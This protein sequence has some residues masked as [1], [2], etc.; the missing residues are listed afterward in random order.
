MADRVG[1][2]L[3]NYRLL[4]LLG[5]GGFAEVYLGEHVFLETQAAIKVLRTQ[6]EGEDIEQFRKEART[7]AHLIHPHIVRVLEFG[8]DGMMPFL[9]MDYA[10]HGSLRQ[11]HPKGSQLPLPLVVSYVKQIAPALH[12]AHQQ[13]LIHRDIKP[14]NMLLTGSNEV[15]LTDFGIATVA[16][17]QSSLKTEA[18]SGTPYY[19]APEQIAGKALPASDQYSLGIVVYEWLTGTQP[20]TGDIVQLIYQHINNTPPP[21][22]EKLPAIAPDVEQV[23]LQTLAKDPHQRFASVVAFATALEEA[24]QTAA[25]VIPAIEAAPAQKAEP[26]PN[27]PPVILRHATQIGVAAQADALFV[28]PRHNTPPALEIPAIERVT[29]P[30]PEFPPTQLVTPESPLQRATA[31]ASAARPAARINLVPVGFGALALTLL[32]F[33]ALNAEL[34]PPFPIFGDLILLFAICGLVQIVT[35]VH[36]LLAKKTFV[37]TALCSYGAFWLAF[38]IPFFLLPDD[39]IRFYFFR[40][41]AYLLLSWTILTGLFILASL[42]ENK[43]L[44]AFSTLLFLSFL[45][46]M[47]GEINYR[48]PLT[49]LLISGWLSILTAL[50]AI[51]VIWYTATHPAQAVM[52][53]PLKVNP[54]PLGLSAFALTMFVF[55]MF[56]TA[57]GY[58]FAFIGGM[59]FFSGLA[60]VYGGLVEFIAGLLALRT[61]KV[62]LGALFC[63]YSV[64]WAVLGIFLFPTVNNHLSELVFELFFFA[65]TIANAILLI[66]LFKSSRIVMIL[67]L[68]ALLAFLA[69]TIGVFTGLYVWNIIGGSFAILTATI[70]WYMML[71]MLLREAGGPFK[72]PVGV[73][74]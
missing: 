37:G 1:Q 31:A 3:G 60:L 36:S 28:P 43:I 24:S 21:M 6:L 69:L 20:F 72:L 59:A 55:G 25:A 15:L 34:F 70:A 39:G 4:Q 74:D 33:G 61:G 47:I 48:V 46:Y 27:E 12:Y 63:A 17:S 23:V 32:G 67:S 42:K 65:W 41:L 13:K 2:Q 9:I 58:N 44:M 26:L 16:H 71:A 18:Y 22:R 5:Y 11:R 57:G 10:P 40:D 64:F 35:G 19:S 68:A 53:A 62:W 49:W 29:P 73:K 7:I 38:A 8:V 51:P 14:E 52:S 56:N 66:T 50:V 54:V 45:T 30:T